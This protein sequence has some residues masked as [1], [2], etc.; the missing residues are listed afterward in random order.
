MPAP[1]QPTIRPL[2]G[3]DPDAWR[4]AESALAHWAFQTHGWLSAWADTLGAAEGAR[5]CPVLVEDAAG[6][7]MLLPL[8]VFPAGAWRELRFLGGIVTDYHAPLLAPDWEARLGPGGFAA[9]WPR[10][11]DALPPVDVVRLERMPAFVEDVPNPLAALP[12]LRETEP[13]LAVALPGTL[14]AYL[15]TR[16]SAW[17]ADTR[18]K[19]RRLN[20]MAPLS[21]R[22]ATNAPGRA[23]ALAEMMARKSRRWLE[24][25]NPDAFRRPAFRGFYA[26]MSESR[27]GDG[28]VHAATLRVGE[29]VV[30]A[31]WGLIHRGRFY[32]L[33]VGW[34]GGEWA[35]YSVGRI[36]I[37]DMLAEAIAEGCAVFDLTVGDE[38]YKFD[39][40]ES[41]MEMRAL[42]AARSAKGRAVLGLA[43]LRE[44][45]RERLKRVSWLRRAVRRALG[46]PPG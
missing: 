8:G 36:I 40:T 44:A 43:A 6:P 13:A 41:R 17:V 30:A 1:A 28:R 35:K 38:P 24:T 22:P 39:W 16:K 46:R 37:E 12:G 23:A 26:R 10:V 34:S 19:R 42:L 29:E 21:Y 18:R 4:Q 7:V 14:A 45:A 11:L 15:K 9:L 32:Y 5:P 3:L 27:P 33:M 31:H 25:G 20:E 2:D